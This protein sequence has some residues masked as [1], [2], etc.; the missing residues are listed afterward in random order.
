MVLKGFTGKVMDSVAEN[1]GGVVALLTAIVSEQED[2]AYAMVL[3]SD[4]IELFGALTGVLLSVLHR[5]SEF[6][7]ITTENYLQELGMIASR[8]E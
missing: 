2:I 3:E 8:S 5:L 4:P 6:S 7:G 1:I